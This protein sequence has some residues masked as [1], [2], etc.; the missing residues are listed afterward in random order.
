[1]IP[2]LFW[3]RWVTTRRRYTTITSQYKPQVINL[4]A[5]KWP[6]FALVLGFGIYLTV[7]PAA[8]PP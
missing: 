7:I 6:A 8:V 3:H 2:V 1:M 5:W 4:R